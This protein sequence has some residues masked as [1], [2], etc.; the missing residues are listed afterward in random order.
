MTA[1]LLK[2]EIHLECKLILKAKCERK[3]CLKGYSFKAN[4]CFW[5]LYV[6]KVENAFPTF[7][8]IFEVFV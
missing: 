1:R 4:S 5:Q 8:L 6:W 2:Y 7:F 3:N